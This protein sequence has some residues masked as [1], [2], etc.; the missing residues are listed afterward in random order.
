M[1]SAPR[2]RPVIG[3]RRVQLPLPTSANQPCLTPGQV[4]RTLD[5][6]EAMGFIEKVRDEHNVT[7]YRP[8]LVARKI[9]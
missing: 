7:R 4:A 6:L 8:R 3:R 9:S 2:K 5:E 1:A